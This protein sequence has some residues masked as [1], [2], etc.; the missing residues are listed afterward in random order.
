MYI[1]ETPW[2][3]KDVNKC[4]E[5]PGSSGLWTGLKMIAFL[6]IQEGTGGG[7]WGDVLELD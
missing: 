6:K 7:G 4:S 1:P 5:F 2:V 3:C